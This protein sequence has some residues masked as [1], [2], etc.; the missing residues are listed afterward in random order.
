MNIMGFKF[1]EMDSETWITA[2]GRRI[3]VHDMELSHLIR[4]IRLLRRREPLIRMLYL[5]RMARYI[6]DA[7]DGAAMACESEAN[8]VCRMSNDEFLTMV[9]P[10]FRR[11]LSTLGARMS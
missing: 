4:T 11:M 7:P 8:Q 3:Q 6:A 5:M 9:S 10:P 2:D 1:A